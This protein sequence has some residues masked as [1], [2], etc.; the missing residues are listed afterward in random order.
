MSTIK[1]ET[2]SGFKWSAIERFSVQGIQFVLGI[3]IAR[4]LQ[5]EVYGIIGMLTIFIAIAQSF[6]DSGFTNAIIRKIDRSPID[7]DTVFYFNICIGILSYAILFFSAPY[8]AIFFSTPILCDVLRVLALNLI[9]NS[10]YAIQVTRL[11]I[12]VDF[13]TQAKVALVSVFFSGLLGIVLAY[14]GFGVWSLVFQNLCGS[15]INVILYWCFSGWRPK[16][17]FSWESFKSMYSFGCKM[18][19]AGLL[20]T[21]YTNATTF[22]IG[23][24]YSAKDLAYYSRGQS[25]AYVPS[26]NITGLIQ[27]V[28]YPVLSKIQNDE[29]RL[30][31]AYRKFICITSMII[32]FGMSCLA[33]MAKPIVLIILTEKW[34]PAIIFVQILCYEMMFD[35][36]CLINLN[37]LKVKGRSD[38]I[39]KLEFIKKS[40]ALGML[41]CAVKFGVVAICIASVIYTQIAIYINTYYTGKLYGLSYK[42]Q[43]KDFMPYLVIA[44]IS[45]LP[46]Y[47][48]TLTALPSFVQLFL[49]IL[50]SF[51]IYYGIL[52]KNEYMKE[53][54][55]ILQTSLKIKKYVNK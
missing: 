16:L 10:M 45:C 41:I 44:T 9:I 26:T 13:K 39:L 25:L 22:F 21:L 37:L 6:V 42:D 34:A 33:A 18:L 30:I 36:I 4:I 31:A 46:A 53:A 24:F 27:R 8:V 5:P 48:I 47:V 23:K 20:H 15:T 11:T 19:F 12:D 1:E 28:T 29:Q 2:V 54:I 43:F 7:Y 38:L 35:H 32:F 51:S 14:N 40:I 52:R 50:V 55:E 49:G 3:I 17:R